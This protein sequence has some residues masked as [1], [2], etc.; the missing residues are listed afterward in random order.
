VSIDSREHKGSLGSFN[1][2]SDGFSLGSFNRGSDGSFNRGSDGSFNRGSDGL[3]LRC[4]DG[5]ADGSGL[6]R[7]YLLVV[8]ARVRSPARG[9]SKLPTKLIK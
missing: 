2:S 1:R 5:N 6:D 9:V 3:G 7:G 8:S 4:F